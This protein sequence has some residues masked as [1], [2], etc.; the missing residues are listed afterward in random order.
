MYLHGVKTGL[1]TF[2]TGDVPRGWD[3]VGPVSRKM[4]AI[5]ERPEGLKYAAI[6]FISAGTRLCLHEAK[7]AKNLHNEATHVL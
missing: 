1:S 5:E 4:G 7:A 3:S 2:R 6:G